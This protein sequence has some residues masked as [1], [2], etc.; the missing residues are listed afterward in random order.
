MQH[1]VLGEQTA[2]VAVGV[3]LPGARHLVGGEVEVCQAKLRR[4]E[5]G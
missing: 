2:V 1:E 5:G 3:A 4:H